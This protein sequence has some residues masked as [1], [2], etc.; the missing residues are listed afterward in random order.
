MAWAVV[1]D[2]RRCASSRISSV[3]RPATRAVRPGRD[4]ARVSHGPVSEGP[5]GAA[6]SQHAGAQSAIVLPP[7]GTGAS[8][9]AALGGSRGVIEPSSAAF[10]VNRVRDVGVNA[11]NH[12]LAVKPALGVAGGGPV[13]ARLDR[14][15]VLLVV[16]QPSKIVTSSAGGHRLVYGSAS[17]WT[18][19]RRASRSWL[20]K[21]SQSEIPA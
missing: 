17:P 13:K 4:F 19:R 7:G 15:P 12:V 2:R 5:D 16:P 9:A 8:S 3:S 1:R 11:F 20:V 10:D 14:G 6:G 21:S 18:N